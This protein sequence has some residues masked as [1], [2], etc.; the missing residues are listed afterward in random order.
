MNQLKTQGTPQV[1]NSAI[2]LIQERIT[3]VNFLAVNPPDILVTPRLG[4]LKMSDFD[5]VEHAIE[6]RYVSTRIKVDDIKMLMETNRSDKQF[7]ERECREPGLKCQKTNNTL[8]NV[9]LR[10]HFYL[11]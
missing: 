3:R 2:K 4:N 1:I 6:E 9:I 5:Q 8:H 11:Q 7:V 10:C